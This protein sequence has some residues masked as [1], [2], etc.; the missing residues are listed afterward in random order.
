VGGGDKEGDEA[1]GAPLQCAECAEEDEGEEA[2]G[3]EE[4]E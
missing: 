3:D 2:L 4:G 1:E